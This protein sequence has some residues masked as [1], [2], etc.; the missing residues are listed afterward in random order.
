[1]CTHVYGEEYGF[2][3]I[4]DSSTIATSVL[5]GSLGNEKRKKTRRKRE[6]E[7]EER[8]EKERGKECNHKHEK[9]TRNFFV[10]A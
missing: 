9:N 3:F 4:F 1:M 6:R 8:G 5:S 2:F 10:F 7:K